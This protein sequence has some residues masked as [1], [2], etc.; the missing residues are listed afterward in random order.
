MLAGA[1]TRRA[2]LRAGFCALV[3]LGG[4]GATALSASGLPAGLEDGGSFTVAEIIDG[5]TLVLDDG[6]Q[7]RLV[8]IQAPKLPL[9]RPGFEA[10]PLAEEARAA[11]EGL[12]RGRTVRLGYGGRRVDRH[13]RVLA[14]LFRAD[15]LWVQGEMLAAGLARTYSFADNRALVAEMLQREGAARAAQ[16][17]IWAHRWYRI[18]SAEELAADP[19]AD[20]DSFQLVEGLVRDA[21]VVRNRGYLNFGDDWK[22]DFTVAIDAASLRLFEAAGLP[23]TYYEGRRIRVRGWLESFNGPSI[24]VTHPEQIEVLAQ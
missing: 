9:G 18:R 5:D 2:L 17:G 22:T 3:A 8:G 7:V 12:T 6:R 14:H 4:G 11:L 16:A 23:P 21:A 15:G 20:L 13:G 19:W 1:S 24:D 10:W